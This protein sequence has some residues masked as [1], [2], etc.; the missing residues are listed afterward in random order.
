MNFMAPI[1]SISLTTPQQ[2]MGQ[3]T[4]GSA[5]VSASVL[6]PQVPVMKYESQQKTDTSIIATS[7]IQVEQPKFENA[8]NIQLWMTKSII[9]VHRYASLLEAAKLMEQNK[10]GCL[11]VV[12]DFGMLVGIITD[13]D[14]VRKVVAQGI[15]VS[16][17]LEQIMTKNVITAESDKTLGFISELMTRHSIKRVPIVDNAKMVGIISSTDIINIFLQLNNFAEAHKIIEMM[18]SGSAGAW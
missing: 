17:P 6:P 7:T 18:Y 15:P 3:V 11:P 12:N 9:T 14:L 5:N 2:S 10:F 1:Q 8:M 13:T 4:F 16:E